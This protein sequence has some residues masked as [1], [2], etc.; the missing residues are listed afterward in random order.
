MFLD[1]FDEEICTS[2]G[3]LMVSEVWIIYPIGII[4]QT[5]FN[6]IIDI[7]LNFV[8]FANFEFLIKI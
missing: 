3:L 4:H 1:T 8:L 5:N 7:G 6:E 2:I